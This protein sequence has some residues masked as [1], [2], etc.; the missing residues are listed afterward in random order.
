V[1]SRA[2]DS[3]AEDRFKPAV[4]PDYEGIA[5]VQRARVLRN[6]PND[7]GAPPPPPAPKK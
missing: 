2:A 7:A 4:P 1:E 6:V 3:I 5:M